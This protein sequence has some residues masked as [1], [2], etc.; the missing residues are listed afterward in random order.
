MELKHIGNMDRFLMKPLLAAA[1]LL[2]VS[3]AAA[4]IFSYGG[5]EYITIDETTCEVGN[6][7]YH[8]GTANI[9]E[10]VTYNGKT[11]TVTQIGRRAFY[12]AKNLTG[13]RVPET[14]TAIYE[15]AFYGCGLGWITFEDGEEPIEF[16]SNGTGSMTRVFDEVPVQNVY[17]GRDFILP[18]GLW[19]SNPPF[20]WN[21]AL[22]IVEI[23]DLV[24]SLPTCA[25]QECPNLMQVT[26]GSGLKS[27]GADAFD[28]SGKYRY[29]QPI[30]T[31]YLV[32][33]KSEIWP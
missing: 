22:Q 14:V 3:T 24:T 13:V 17:I 30:V 27:I 9:P 7:K 21:D 1:T 26:I 29:L 11:Y 20:S 16:K 8:S 4:D 12:E 19:E 31:Q 15:D 33:N 28:R 32:C 23:G 2:T 10:Q 6:N 5:L 18:G 25:F